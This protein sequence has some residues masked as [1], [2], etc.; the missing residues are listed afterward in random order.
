MLKKISIPFFV[1]ISV[2][3]STFSFSKNQDTSAS[4]LIKQNLKNHNYE[5]LW[6][7]EFDFEIKEDEL[8]FLN[9]KD[10][11]DDFYVD[12]VNILLSK[13]VSVEYIPVIAFCKESR[14]AAIVNYE[15]Y[16]KA[17]FCSQKFQ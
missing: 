16:S 5:L 2:F 8:S 1:I 10:N 13:K 7:I 14:V 11:P 3:F 15:V 6:N 9:I 17:P 12:I 4:Y